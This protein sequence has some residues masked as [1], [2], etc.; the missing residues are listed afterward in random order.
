MKVGLRKISCYDSGDNKEGENEEMTG[1][2]VG[3]R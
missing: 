3:G 2:G 1:E